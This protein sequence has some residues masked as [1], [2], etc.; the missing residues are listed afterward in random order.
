[1]PSNHRSFIFG[2]TL[3]DQLQFIP[4]EERYKFLDAILSYGLDGEEAAFEGKDQALWAG[5]KALLLA[6]NRKHWSSQLNGTNGGR[7]QNNLPKPTDNPQEPTRTYRNPQEPIGNNRN[8]PAI[9]NS[10]IGI[11]NS[12]SGSEKDS[13]PPQFFIKNIHEE[14]EKVGFPLDTGLLQRIAESGIDPAWIQGPNSFV[15]FAKERIMTEY[16]DKPFEEQRLLFVRAFTW[17][18]LRNEYPA[19]RQN[20]QKETVTAARKNI[21]DKISKRPTVCEHCGAEL[22]STY[23]C[24]GCGY[25]FWYDDEKDGWIFEQHFNLVDEFRKVLAEKRTVKLSENSEGG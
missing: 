8:P 3:R 21:F 9:V 20:E 25:Q 10:D 22:D 15:E 7:P 6:L 4:Q 18:N 14:A 19:W 11:E 17:E 13:P 24:P 2:D 12:G 1:M 16:R 5:M 23:V